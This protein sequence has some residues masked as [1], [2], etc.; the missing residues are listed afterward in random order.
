M[1]PTLAGTPVTMASRLTAVSLSNLPDLSTPARLE[2]EA[3]Q[4]RTVTGWVVAFRYCGASCP[5]QIRIP[6]SKRQLAITLDV[7]RKEAERTEWDCEA[8]VDCYEGGRRVSHR[9]VHIH[10]GRPLSFPTDGGTGRT[11]GSF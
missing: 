2:W 4:E 8:V 9:I 11:P 5:Y 3:V 1:K 6:T 10:T 7:E